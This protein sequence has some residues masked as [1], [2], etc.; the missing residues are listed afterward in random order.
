M[1]IA[2]TGA[3]GFV[4][5]NLIAS[6]AATK[7]KIIALSRSPIENLPLNAEWRHC[8]LFSTTST[9]EAL[10]GADVVFYL[11]HSMMPSSRLFQGN[12]RDTD[13]LI[14]D[15][16][17]RS[18]M[19][20]NIKQ[21][22]YLGGIVPEGF[23]S[24]HLQSRQEVEGVLQATKIPVTVFRSGMVVGQGGSSFEI[25]NSLVRKLPVMI[26]PSWTQ[27]KTQAVYIDDVISI[28]KDSVSNKKYFH[29]T[30]DI[31]NGEKLTYRD[32]MR[33]MAE[34]LKV[35]R[36]MFPVPI[37]ST[38][39]SKLWVTWF[40]NSHYAL[41]SPLIDSLVCD[42][43][44]EKPLPLIQKFISFKTFASMLDEVLQKEIKPISARPKRKISHR[45]SVRSIQRLPSVPK[46]NSEWMAREYMNW[47]PKVF[48][49]LILVDVEPSK[50]LVAFRIFFLKK[51]ILLLQY[52]HGNFEEDR[53]K[54]HIIG[55]LLTRT[56][57][58]GWLEFRQ[59]QNKKY[60]LTAIHEFVPSLP[61]YIYVITQAPMHY[62]VMNAFGRHIAEVNGNL[63]RN[64]IAN[65]NTK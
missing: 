9:L 32:L 22:V 17:S 3:S 38:G 36:F 50:D 61:W 40:G 47:L 13:L 27:S 31:V 24:K 52:I 11:V 18:C 10:K 15:N 23:I 45:K 54:F 60:S 21:I 42:L 8:E 2:I 41:V 4:G 29:Q 35:R 58:T 20:N 59:V 43:P 44:Q 65:L 14:A 49:S 33:I 6:L 26:L 25:L 16:I 55:G 37:N 5:Q 48:R 34:K 28:L 53:Q 62:L 46:R 30:I 63:D 56:S 64:E 12:F 39:F 1:K 19:Q 57:D 51:P 7:H